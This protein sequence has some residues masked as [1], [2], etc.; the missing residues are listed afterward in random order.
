MAA[1]VFRCPFTG[2]QV[3]GWFADDSSGNG[4]ESYEGVVC[5]ACRQ[6]HLVNPSTGKVLGMDEEE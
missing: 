2:L 1:V 3:Q 5:T 6:L 4:G